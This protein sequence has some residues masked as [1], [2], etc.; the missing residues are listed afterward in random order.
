MLP[1][2]RSGSSAAADDDDFEVEKEVSSQE[3]YHWKPS[4]YHHYDIKVYAKMAKCA[5]EHDNKAAIVKFTH[6]LQHTVNENTV[7]NLR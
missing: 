3:K 1:Q 6:E 7:R 4:K 5:C 2:N